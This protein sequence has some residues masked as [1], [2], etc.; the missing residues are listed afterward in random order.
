[1]YLGQGPHYSQKIFGIRPVQSHGRATCV[2]HCLNITQEKE[3]ER[4]R[5]REGKKRGKKERNI[6]REI[7][8]SFCESGEGLR[9]PRVRG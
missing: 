4:E 1:M 6:I 8:E 3:R 9:L 7:R 2:S 5:E